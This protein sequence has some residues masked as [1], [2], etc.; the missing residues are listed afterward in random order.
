[1]IYMAIN[2]NKSIHIFLQQVD[3]NYAWGNAGM[4]V[5]ESQGFTI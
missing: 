4:I 1:M 5:S 3:Q 2:R